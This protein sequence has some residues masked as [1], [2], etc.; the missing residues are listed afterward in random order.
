LSPQVGGE[1]G[2]FDTVFAFCGGGGGLAIE[3]AETSC[4]ISSRVCGIIGSGLVGS[5]CFILV[6]GYRHSVA[7]VEHLVQG[8]P[9]EHLT[10][11]AAHS[12]QALAPFGFELSLSSL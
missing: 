6:S 4:C 8:A 10:F 9:P 11:A 2:M 7:F 5:S 12:V 3:G 1:K